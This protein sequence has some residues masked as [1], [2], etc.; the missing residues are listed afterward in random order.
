MSSSECKGFDIGS[1]PTPPGLSI[2]LIRVLVHA[3]TVPA[4]GPS[5]RE[6][7][8][9]PQCC[10]MQPP[11][12]NGSHPGGLCLPF[13]HRVCKNGLAAGGEQGTT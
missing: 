11:L 5:P 7:A 4:P 2:F 3:A 8:F 9:C 6:T 1:L 13:A 10:T 12:R